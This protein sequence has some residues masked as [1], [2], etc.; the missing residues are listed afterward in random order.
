MI[1]GDVE[2]EGF[3]PED[4]EVVDIFAPPE[5]T[6]SLEIRRPICVALIR[7]IVGCRHLPDKCCACT[8]IC[9]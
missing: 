1:P 2:H 5:K 7:D 8:S 6:F 3:F 4:T 9:S